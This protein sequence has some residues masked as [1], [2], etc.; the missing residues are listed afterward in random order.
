MGKVLEAA[1][2]LSQMDKGQKHESVVQTEGSSQHIEKKDVENVG[3]VSV[4]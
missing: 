2:R 1:S 3:Q 4:E